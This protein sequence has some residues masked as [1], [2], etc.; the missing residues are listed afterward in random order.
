MSEYGTGAEAGILGI[1]G[2]LGMTIKGKNKQTK[3]K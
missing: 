1:A 2:I 3:N